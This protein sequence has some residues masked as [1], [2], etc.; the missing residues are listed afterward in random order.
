MRWAL[1]E[2]VRLGGHDSSWV[3]RPAIEPTIQNQ[4]TKVN[5]ALPAPATLG[6]VPQE[7]AGNVGQR[8]ASMSVAEHL[9]PQQ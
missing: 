9:Q 6:A 7:S 8:V 4:I 2:G 5:V 3:S 1:Q